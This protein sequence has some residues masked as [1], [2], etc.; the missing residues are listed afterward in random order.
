MYTEIPKRKQGSPCKNSH[1]RCFETTNFDR[2]HREELLFVPRYTH[3]LNSFSS[4]IT[5]QNTHFNRYIETSKQ[6]Q[7]A[8]TGV[9]SACRREEN[10]HNLDIWVLL[11]FGLKVGEGLDF[12]IWD[13]NGA[14]ET[15]RTV[16]PIP[17][18]LSMCRRRL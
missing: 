9:H 11:I 1:Q 3:R 14:H 10:G 18:V 15:E 7:D 8:Y 5:Q 4:T 16:F 17:Q 6:Q 2:L 13:L 12:Q